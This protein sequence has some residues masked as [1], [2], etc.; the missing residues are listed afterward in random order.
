MWKMDRGRHSSHRIQHAEDTGRE[1]LALFRK[2]KKKV[3]VQDNRHPILI[4]RILFV[5]GVCEEKRINE[6]I[7]SLS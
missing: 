7:F 1:I 6:I 2:K 3:K 5:W 4:L